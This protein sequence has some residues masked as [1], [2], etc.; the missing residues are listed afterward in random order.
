VNHDHDRDIV[1][2]RECGA[3]FDLVKQ[4]YYDNLCPSC[5]D[6]ENPERNWPICAECDERIPPDEQAS[7]T[8]EG[9]RRDPSAVS[10]PVHE[11]CRPPGSAW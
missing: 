8:V 2:C 10:L 1:E 7:K 4:V 11:D 6:E 9:G 3:R 5:M